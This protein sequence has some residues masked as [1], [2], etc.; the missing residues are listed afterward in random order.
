LP[1]ALLAQL[2][3][4]QYQEVVRTTL[5]GDAL[6]IVLGLGI[7]MLGASAAL[8]FLLRQ[9][10]RDLS[11]LW[12]G[13]FAMV[14]GLRLLMETSIVPFT[15]RLSP[16]VRGYAVFLLT[17]VVPIPGLVFGSEMF[18]QWRPAIRRLLAIF[19]LF[20]IAAIIADIATGRPGTLRVA[21][22]WL[23]LGIWAIA[24]VAVFRQTTVVSAS[25]RW[26]IAIFGATIVL[27]NLRG[28]GWLRIPFDPEPLGFACFLIG[29]G[30]AL[31]ARILGNEEHLSELKKELEIATRIQTSILP[32]EMPRLTGL[33]VAAKYMPMTSVA[34]DFYEFL[35]VDD[36]RIGILIADVAGHG[37]PAALIASMVKI[38]IASQAANAAD[39]GRVLAGMNQILC[40]KM[41]GQYI[42]AAY[43]FID[44]ENGMFRYA[45]A[46]HPPLLLWRAAE[47][48][49][50][51][52]E[53][54]GL[55]LGITA[56]APYSF[57]EGTFQRGDRFLL[58]TDGLME[59]ANEKDEFFGE[60]RVREV[61]NGAQATSPIACCEAL[62]NDMERFTGRNRG[63]LP[64]DDLTLVVVDAGQR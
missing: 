41:Q 7:T 33:E 26:G 36:R 59:A 38:A 45:G 15:L 60:A 34:G 11:S 55:L 28:L 51:S 17:Y 9:R 52:L 32:R 16:S 54:N 64:D 30:H 47:Q 21:N 19:G 29:L 39:P 27:T 44:L 25:L 8:F 12:F 6:A 2:T 61:L 53:E 18:P 13:T 1:A 3:V 23:A 56:R 42:S 22:N 5:R 58:Y 35:P 62:V 43:L 14:Y 57:L 37:V 4:A 48:R 20:A 50:E 46:G 63:R 10:S 49:T 24:A 40:G 31:A